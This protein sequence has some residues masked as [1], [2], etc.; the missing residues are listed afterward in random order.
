[1]AWVES[2]QSVGTH[3]KTKRAARELGV[4]RVLMI[5]HLHLF[6]HWALD[7]AQD[8]DLSDYEPAD[9]ADAAD[10]D[11]DPQQFFN[12]LLN[13]G[14]G[15]SAGFIEYDAEN[16]LVIHDWWEYAG[17]LIARRQADAERKKQDRAAKSEGSMGYVA[18]TSEGCPADVPPTSGT[19]A[20]VNQPTVN[21]PIPTNQPEK[22][23]ARE[24]RVH[25]PDPLFEAIVEVCYH[26]PH[27]E[28]TDDE[29][30]RVNKALPQLRKIKA[31][32][33]GV[34]AR[35]EEYRQRSPEYPF[36]PQTL[37]KNWSDLGIHRDM[38]RASPSRGGARNGELNGADRLR[39]LRAEMNRESDT[40]G[41]PDEQYRGLIPQ[42]PTG[43]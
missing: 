42:L 23:D 40:G 6:W 30:G 41:S 18:Q 13:C 29:R 9:I 38:S 32:A 34:R 1:M 19:R 7:Y 12:A 31:D 25:T 2:H 26:R 4:S 28:I 24:T 39:L 22:N 5:G 11:G 15:D 3:P 21:Q 8:G 37:T 10:W 33:A 27:Q 16:R 14:P 36:T 20:R 35:F 17:K 43:G